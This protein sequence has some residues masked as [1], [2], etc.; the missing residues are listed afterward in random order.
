M[1]C[2][3]GHLL[4]QRLPKE[5]ALGS[6][7]KGDPRDLEDPNLVTLVMQEGP[8]RLRGN[9]HSVSPAPPHGLSRLVPGPRAAC[10]PGSCP[11]FA[12]QACGC[13]DLTSRLEAVTGSVSVILS[14]CLC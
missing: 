8:F 9:I 13:C 2:Q 3:S 10:M 14:A 4:E 11:V 12:S 7:S 1:D 6:A 5:L